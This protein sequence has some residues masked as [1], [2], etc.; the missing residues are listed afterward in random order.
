LNILRTF[1]STCNQGAKNITAMKP[2]L[3]WLLGQ[4]RR[5]GVGDQRA[6]YDWLKAKFDRPADGA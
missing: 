5:V 6:V 3:I 2:D 4:V 1:C